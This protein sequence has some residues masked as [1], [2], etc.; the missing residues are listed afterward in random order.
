VEE[1]AVLADRVVIL[2]PRPAR[3]AASLEIPAPRPR[4]RTDPAVVETVG[5]ALAALGLEARA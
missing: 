2:S 5:A 3:V 1:A 4:R